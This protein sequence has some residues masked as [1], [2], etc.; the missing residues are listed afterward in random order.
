[1]NKKLFRGAIL[2]TILLSLINDSST[3]GTHGY[4]IFTAIQRKFGVRLGPSTL[5]PELKH[6]EGQGLIESQW[7]FAVGKARRQ[8]RITRRGQAL[9]K[10]YYT[11]FKVVIPAFVACNP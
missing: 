5:Y 7:D 4:A 3:R 9:L 8:Y 11:E 6:L 2:E 1:M 10:E